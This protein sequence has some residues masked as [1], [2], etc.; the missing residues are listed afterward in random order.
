MA[1]V[2]LISKFV[3]VPIRVEGISMLPTYRERGVNFVNRLA[4]WFHPPRRG[5]VVAIQM[6][7]PHVMLCK[8]I[9]GLPGETVEFHQGHVFINGQL[10]EEPYV[11]LECR[12]EHGP[13]QVRAD[14]YYVAGD[15]RSM[16]FYSH[17]RGCAER[18]RIVGKLL[19]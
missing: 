5:D 4:Y 17:D 14:E 7:G 9:I 12:W 10:L 13:E 1:A 8:R 18:W 16:D 11:K 15:N 3:L 2:V 6:A 19:R